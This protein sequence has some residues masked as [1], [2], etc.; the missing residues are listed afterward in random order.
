LKAVVSVS[1]VSNIWLV[2]QLRMGTPD[3]VSRCVSELRQ[4]QREA[5]KIRQK[6]TN[7]DS[8]EKVL[9]VDCFKNCAARRA[10]TWIFVPSIFKVG[11][12]A[13]LRLI[14]LVAG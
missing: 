12:R 7:I 10:L 1:T 3:G 11:T 5:E 13:Q 2:E 4:D 8:A 9:G 6:I 14:F